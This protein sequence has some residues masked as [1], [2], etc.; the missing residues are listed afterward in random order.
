[1][2]TLRIQTRPFCSRCSSQFMHCFWHWVHKPNHMPKMVQLG[3][4]QKLGAWIPHKLT[5]QLRRRNW[6]NW[7]GKNCLTLLTHQTLLHQ[8][9]TYSEAWPFPSR[10]K[11]L[12]ILI[13][14]NLRSKLS[15]RLKGQTSMLRAYFNYLNVGAR[16]LILMA[17]ILLIYSFYF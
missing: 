5:D 11:I 10:R 4:V 15:F 17:N 12:M 3:F 8:I 2:F 16:S 9:T 7:A 13:I 1:M 14:W 6:I